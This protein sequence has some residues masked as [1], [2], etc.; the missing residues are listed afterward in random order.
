MVSQKKPPAKKA[1]SEKAFHKQNLHIKSQLKNCP[2]QKRT[3]VF[4]KSP[5]EKG[6]FKM[7]KVNMYLNQNFITITLNY[8]F[9]YK[10][11]HNW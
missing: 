3:S 5:S 7:D 9:F 11:A 6:I 2:I 8:C 4:K 10:R 1:Y